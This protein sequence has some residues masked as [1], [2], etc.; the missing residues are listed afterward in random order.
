MLNMNY[1][2]SQANIKQFQLLRY[3]NEN[4]CDDH[5]VSRISIV[6]RRDKIEAPYYMVTKIA[7]STCLD[8]P[9][10]GVIHAMDVLN[11][12]RRHNL[13]EEKY[14]EIESLIGESAEVDENE[15]QLKM[16]L[17]SRN[18][19]EFRDL[20]KNYGEL[21]EKIDELTD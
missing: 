5:V 10:S 2:N 18:D 12:H 1:M 19:A 7:L 13:T 3:I 17:I 21:F 4:S 11:H 6:L 8:N 14:N 15:K 9:D 20:F 16:T